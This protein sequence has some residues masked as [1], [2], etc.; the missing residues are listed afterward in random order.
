[1]SHFNSHSTNF[2][3]LCE[4]MV[5]FLSFG[6]VMFYKLY[7]SVLQLVW[8]YISNISV[9]LYK[10]GSGCGVM[11]GWTIINT[12]V[13]LSGGYLSVDWLSSLFPPFSF[14]EWSLQWFLVTAMTRN[15]ADISSYHGWL[16]CCGTCAKLAVLYRK[17]LACLLSQEAELPDTNIRAV[18][19]VVKAF[20]ATGY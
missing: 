14:A 7:M 18:K 13:C 10:F 3:V 5:K 6:G 8:K 4:I 11:C 16:F 20:S 19:I 17:S 2:C 15:S 9:M 1:M 12:W